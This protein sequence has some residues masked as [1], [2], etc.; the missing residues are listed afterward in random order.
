MVKCSVPVCENKHHGKGYCKKHY[1]AYVLTDYYKSKVCSVQGCDRPVTTPHHGEYYCDMHY[2]RL[3]RNEDLGDGHGKRSREFFSMV[4]ELAK[5]INPLEYVLPSRES[6]S[7][8]S[9]LYYGNVCM[10]CGWDKGECDTHHKMP[11][12]SGG[13]NTINNAKILCPNCHR[14]KH[15]RKVKRFSEESVQSF[16]NLIN[17]RLGEYKKAD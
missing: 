1:K 10:E 9:K 13:K 5:S 7:I 12:S 8:Y 15:V 2:T 16:K 3:R 4:S 6:W 17:T 11:A 14:L